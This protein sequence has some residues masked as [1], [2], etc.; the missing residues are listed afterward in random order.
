MNREAHAYATINGTNML[1]TYKMELLDY[2][3]GSPVALTKYIEVPGRPGLLDATLALNGKVNYS[4]RPIK[5]TFHIRDIK[6]AEYMTLKSTLMKLFNGT[7]SKV[8]FSPDPDWYYKGRFKLEFERENN[9][10]AKVTFTC[11]EAFPYKLEEYSVEYA[12]ASTSVKLPVGKDYNGPVTINVNKPISVQFKSI[13]YQLVAGNNVIP[14]IQF[15][16]GYNSVRFVVAEATTVTLTYERG[17][18]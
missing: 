14:E 12:I 2:D 3:T 11:E 16:S 9:V 1:T 8:A 4:T 7:V 15:S 17:V 18:L 6:T 5:I 10:T 13:T